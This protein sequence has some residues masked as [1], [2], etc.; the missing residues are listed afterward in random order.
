MHVNLC[1]KTVQVGRRKCLVRNNIQLRSIM[2]NHG[3]HTRCR[4]L[5]SML[6]S[7]LHIGSR[8][9]PLL[10]GILL[11]SLHFLAT[12]ILHAAD[13][14]ILPRAGCSAWTHDARADIVEDRGFLHALWALL[15]FLCPSLVPLL[16]RVHASSLASESHTTGTFRVETFFKQNPPHSR[17]TS[18]QP[19]RDSIALCGI[20]GSFLSTLLGSGH[21]PAGSWTTP[22]SPSAATTSHISML[23]RRQI[24][25]R[26]EPCAD[27]P[28]EHEELREEVRD[29][30]IPTRLT[31]TN[32]NVHNQKID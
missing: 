8:R 30:Q 20:S 21:A 19:A 5:F 1:W 28:E 27:D 15:S 22:R 14:M 10:Q 16:S 7:V 2:P 25:R 9:P 6:R 24:R 31:C 23:S 4:S 32:H 3:R 17:S 12:P 18:P 11:C 29:T 13:G 26:N